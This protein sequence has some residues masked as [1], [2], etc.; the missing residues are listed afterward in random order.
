MIKI[1]IGVLVTAAILYGLFSWFCLFRDI[2]YKI[3][4]KN[5]QKREQSEE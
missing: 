1:I 4:T 3:K 2:V 5:L